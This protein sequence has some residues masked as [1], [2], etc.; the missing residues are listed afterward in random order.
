[1]PHWEKLWQRLKR[2]IPSLDNFIAFVVVVFFVGSCVHWQS[3]G[4]V[5]IQILDSIMRH[6]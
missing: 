5:L 6:C 3:P 2:V 4:T 1:M